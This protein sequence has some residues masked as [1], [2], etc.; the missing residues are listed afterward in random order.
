[1]TYKASHK[2]MPSSVPPQKTKVL[3]STERLLYRCAQS[4][5]RGDHAFLRHAYTVM[6]RAQ[7][8]PGYV[9]DALEERFP[10]VGECWQTPLQGE[11]STNLRQ[12]IIYFSAK[13][14][15]GPG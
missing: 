4:V 9:T 5:Q 2:P 15:C 11:R 12:N 6:A 8:V 7:T 1:M 10:S 14:P 3:V 13:S